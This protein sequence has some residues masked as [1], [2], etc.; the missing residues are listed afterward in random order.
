MKKRMGAQKKKIAAVPAHS[1]HCNHG[2]PPMFLCPV[3]QKANPKEV[4]MPRV[5]ATNL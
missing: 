1:T 2:I 4:A 5:H 3:Q